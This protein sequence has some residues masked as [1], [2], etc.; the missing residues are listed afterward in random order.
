MSQNTILIL[1]ESFIY[2]LVAKGSQMDPFGNTRYN[3]L[4]DIQGIYLYVQ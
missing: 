2:N 4:L 3:S 1:I